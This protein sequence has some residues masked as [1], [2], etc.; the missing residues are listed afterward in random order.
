M[1]RTVSLYEHTLK[2]IAPCATI[3]AFGRRRTGKST[4]A[5]H[6]I[7]RLSDS[8]VPRFVA[9]VGNS[10]SRLSYSRLIHPL[11]CHPADVDHLERL[12]QWQ[13]DRVAPHR[14]AYEADERR[15]MEEDP[16]YQG[17]DYEPPNELRL[18]ILF[19]DVGK[20]TKFMNSKAVSTL[21]FDG[22]HLLIDTIFLMQYFSQLPKGLRANIDYALFQAITSS[23]SIKIF[24]KELVG[25]ATCTLTEFEFLI[26]AATAKKGK[27]LVVDLTRGIALNEK[28][29]YARIPKD[30]PR[31][32]VGAPH[33]LKYAR[34][35]YLSNITNRHRTQVQQ[36][37][38]PQV[39]SF[40]LDVSDDEDGNDYR[41]HSTLSLN[42]RR[43]IDVNKL[44]EG[45]FTFSDKRG[46]AVNVQ[47]KSM[48]VD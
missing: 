1:S 45:R 6:V 29:F 8:G 40:D 20:N 38:P 32:R 35:H 23:E 10:D 15:K 37:E 18:C 12:I 16:E 14:E 42:R 43:D 9:Y 47:L 2:N 4:T 7:K 22:R 39:N 13:N 34:K 17:V 19:D 31:E 36:Y 24:W 30:P 25:N 33:V 44:R 11:Y 3:V 26:S 41:N 5:K 28:I 48:K 27:I 21:F 46:G